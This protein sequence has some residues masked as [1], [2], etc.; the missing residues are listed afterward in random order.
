MASSK[1][2]EG[3]MLTLEQFQRLSL[4]K[5]SIC[6]GKVID[7]SQLH[8]SLGWVTETL[9]EMGW[10]RLCRISESSFEGALK[11]F[12]VTLQVS[13][14]SSITGYVKGTKLTISE[15]LLVELLGCPNSGHKLR[16]N[17]LVDHVG[18]HGQR[19][20]TE[21]LNKDSLVR[22]KEYLTESLS[23]S[24]ERY[25][26]LVDHVGIHGQ[27]SLTEALNKDSLVRQKKYPT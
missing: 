18:I 16:Y 15:E 20:L 7:F 10:A 6:P 23:K 14:E 13:S 4:A 9:E 26:Q 8:G 19:S 25:N 2:S 11:A 21:A 22:Q 5:F 24:R 3:T 27:R 1:A 17:Q 12:F